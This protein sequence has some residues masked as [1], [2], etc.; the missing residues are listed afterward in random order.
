MFDG[1]VRALAWEGR[2]LTIGFASGR[3]PQVPAGLL[4]VKNL[5]VVGFYW[6]AYLAKEP[7]LVQESLD[8]LFAM[9][10]RGVLK[11]VVS[12]TFPLEQGGE[13]IAALGG[14]KA[15]GKVVIVP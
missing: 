7:H 3:I 5:S 12:A 10:S 14:R 2:L 1:S 6:G 11:P 8:K 4:L 15:T 9:L 13:A